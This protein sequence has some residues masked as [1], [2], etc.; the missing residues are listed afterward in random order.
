MLAGAR[1]FC[2]HQAGHRCHEGVLSRAKLGQRCAFLERFLFRLSRDVHQAADGVQRQ[3]GGLPVPVRAGLPVVGDGCHYQCRIDFPQLLVTQTQPLH[4]PRGEVLHQD[5]GIPDHIQ[6]D[7]PSNGRFEVE[8]EALLG[9]VEIEE[10]GPGLDVGR[11]GGEGAKAP[12]GIA[13]DRPFHLDH[14]RAQRREQLGAVGAGEILGQ[15]NDPH[16]FKETW[17]GG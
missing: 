11:P 16:P 12:H 9:G 8:G 1:L 13:G 15:V 3:L 2:M 5:L 4:C 6:D 10:P 7:L 17:H 14:L